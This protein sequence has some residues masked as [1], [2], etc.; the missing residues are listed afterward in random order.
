M[1]IAQCGVKRTLPPSTLST[2]L[3]RSAR[4]SAS[5]SRFLQE[6]PRW[7]PRSTWTSSPSY[8]TLSS[9]LVASS[10]RAAPSLAYSRVGLGLSAVLL[11]G[12]LIHTSPSRIKCDSLSA[13]Y[14]SSRSG[15]DEPERV[16]LSSLGF[17]TVCGICA[18]VFIKKGLKTI[19]FFLGG[20][21]VLAQYLGSQSLLKMDW[22][23]MS[24]R[25][26]SVIDRAAGG[27]N[28]VQARGWAGSRLGRI[29]NRF[30]DFLTADFG[31][32]ATFLA[33]LAL[34]LRIG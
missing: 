8:S 32:R 1:L 7:I 30:A 13:P 4:A 20:L 21:F 34:G 10:W 27:P 12:L 5:R 15:L 19:A 6:Q 23:R 33:G 2:L 24:T 18:G 16:Q 9:G 3:H 28:P 26:N 14:V 11:G 31:P 17:G 22:A 29:A 25:Y